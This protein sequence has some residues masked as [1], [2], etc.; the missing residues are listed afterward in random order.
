MC[1]GRKENQL[2]FLL[3]K[4]FRSEIILHVSYSLVNNF[5]CL[6]IYVSVFMKLNKYI[7]KVYLNFLSRLTRSRRRCNSCSSPIGGCASRTKA[8][9][10]WKVLC[11]W[12]RL[13][14]L[15]IRLILYESSEF[16][17]SNS[18]IKYVSPVVRTARWGSLMRATGGT[19]RPMKQSNAG[20]RWYTPAWTW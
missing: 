11:D 18:T 2:P 4:L 9:A 1:R 16:L 10:S 14:S 6:M 20:H 13:N 8:T 17:P 12:L 19:C 5:I 15:W 3:L 7:K